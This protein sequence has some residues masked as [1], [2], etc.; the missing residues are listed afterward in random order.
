[1]VNNL[2]SIILASMGKV[3]VPYLLDLSCGISESVDCER[4]GCKD[5][6]MEGNGGAVYQNF[7][8]HRI[9]YVI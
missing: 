5:N 8:Y 7:V 2:L 1:M 3:S 4:M 6:S 9:L